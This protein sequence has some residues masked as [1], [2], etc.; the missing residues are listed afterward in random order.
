MSTEVQLGALLA[1][2]VPRP[3]HSSRP[4]WG[5]GPWGRRPSVF[6]SPW[7][8]EEISKEVKINKQ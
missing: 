8:E 1:Q 7:V 2:R 6:I 4:T 5:G 3:V